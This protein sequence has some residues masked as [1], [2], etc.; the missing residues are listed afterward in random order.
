[1]AIFY[2]NHKK[3]CRNQYYI[4]YQSDSFCVNKS[5]KNYKKDFY[6]K[7]HNLITEYYQRPELN[8]EQDFCLIFTYIHDLSHKII[9]FFLEKKKLSKHS[10]MIKEYYLNYLLY[11]IHILCI[12]V[13]Y[14]NWIRNRKWYKSLYYQETNVKTLQETIFFWNWNIAW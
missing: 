9:I 4:N 5:I 12:R 6:K 13:V 2:Q 1:M 14:T 8:I 11:C 7:L 10:I 3:N